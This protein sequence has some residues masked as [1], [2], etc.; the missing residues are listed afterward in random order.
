VARDAF[1]QCGDWSRLLPTAEVGNPW[2]VST[3]D[4]RRRGRPWSPGADPIEVLG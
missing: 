4:I 3:A 1:D 2:R